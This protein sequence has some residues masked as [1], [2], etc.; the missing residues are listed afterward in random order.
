MSRDLCEKIREKQM[1]FT[2]MRLDLGDKLNKRRSLSPPIP[3]RLPHSLP[4]SLRPSL[5][6]SL[7][8]IPSRSTPPANALNPLSLSLPPSLIHKTHTA[9]QTEGSAAQ[10][11]SRPG[12][13]QTSRQTP[14]GFSLLLSL[15]LF[16]AFG[17]KWWHHSPPGRH[18]ERCC[19]TGEW[20]RLQG[21]G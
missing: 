13:V 8:L 7:S 17:A 9:T 20:C 1:T 5:P 4:P 15:T 3:L 11:D 18:D 6:P 10:G 14:A 12:L 16:L 2:E 19:A 21:Q